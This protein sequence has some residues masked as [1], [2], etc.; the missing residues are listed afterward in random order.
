MKSGAGNET[1]EYIR[2]HIDDFTFSSVKIEGIA[3]TFAQTKEIIERGV[4]AGVPAHDVKKIICIKHGLECL[5]ENYREPLDFD[6]YSAYNAMVAKAD[7]EDAGNIRDPGS[8]FVT[9]RDG[10]VF[11]P[12][13]AS[14]ELFNNILSTAIESSYDDAE[15]ACTLFLNL[16]RAQFFSDGNKRTALMAAN[17]LLAN[18]DAR[19]AFLIPEADAPR[20]LEILID[21]YAGDLSLADAAWDIE[22]ICINRDISEDRTPTSQEPTLETFRAATEAAQALAEVSAKEKTD[23]E[24]MNLHDRQ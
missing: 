8:V 14:P 13:A 23:G 5:L 21:Y 11:Y 10:D 4:A 1:V 18:R 2:R 16:C 24:R 19:C 17:H 15:A 20:V 12:D 9:M 6:T 22:D 7:I 3:S